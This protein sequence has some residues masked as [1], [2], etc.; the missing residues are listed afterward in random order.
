MMR[1]SATL[2][3]FCSSGSSILA[4]PTAGSVD[5]ALVRE[6]SCCAR[7]TRESTSLHQTTW[8][9][10]SAFGPWMDDCCT[11]SVA[12]V[13]SGAVRDGG[14]SRA[15]EGVASGEAVRGPM[16]MFAN[17]SDKVRSC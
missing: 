2:T 6:C 15:P 7:S 17:E 16:F 9:T 8:R 4:G 13:G 12:S 5:V 1:G 10:G 11:E 3:S 14:P